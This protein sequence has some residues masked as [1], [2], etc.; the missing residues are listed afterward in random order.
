MSKER[1]GYDMAETINYTKEQIEA[2]TPEQ[3]KRAVATD[4]MGL[5][6][7]HYDKDHPDNC[8]YMLFNG[9]DAVADD[10]DGWHT[11]ERKTEEEAWADCPDYLNDISAAWKVIEAIQAL[12]EINGQQVRLMI[13]MFVLRQRYQISIVDY[14]S[15]DNNCLAEVI[16]ESAPYAISKVALLALFPEGVS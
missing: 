9:M 4:V 13:R 15:K 2:M 8:Y 16:H 10:Y 7:Y 14:L 12:K 11:A 3:L 1:R 5:H 6:M